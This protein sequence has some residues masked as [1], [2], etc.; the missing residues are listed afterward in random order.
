[1]WIRS[2]KTAT[3]GFRAPNGGKIFWR[4][5]Q[6]RILSE[7]SP[8]YNSFA[9]ERIPAGFFLNPFLIVDRIFQLGRNQVTSLFMKSSRPGIISVVFFAVILLIADAQAQPLVQ[10]PI[11]VYNSFGA[12]N[13]YNTS[14]A[15]GVS[16]ASVSGGYRGQAQFFIPGISGYLDQIQL[17]TI[18]ESGSGLSN[19]YIAQD[20]GS[21]IPGNILESWIGVQNA[22]NGLLTIN[23]AVQPLLQAGQEYWLCDEPGAANS[24]NAWYQNNQG[25]SPGDAFD[26][27]EW[28]WD[29]IPAG[30]ETAGVFNVSVMPVP[31]P[32]VGALAFLGVIFLT[33]A[34]LSRWKSC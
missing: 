27:S 5:A 1:L 31:E 12:G 17:A 32:P 29:T 20:N 25:I 19:F 7:K 30:I 13:S 33:R 22:A 15:W 16:G 26:R 8:D 28:G 3:D 21:G 11:S 4:T 23:S 14:I 9:Q 10:P 6:R 24:Y 2:N 34:A 18:H